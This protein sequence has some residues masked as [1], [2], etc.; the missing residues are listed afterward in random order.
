MKSRRF[1][2]GFLVVSMSLYGLGSSGCENYYNGSCGDDEDLR[3]PHNY[4][5]GAVCVDGRAACP[6]G[7]DFCWS[8]QV[9]AGR[10]NYVKSCDGPCI[11]CPR[12]RGACIIYHKDTDD[13]SVRC[14]ETINDCWSGEGFFVARTFKDQDQCATMGPGCL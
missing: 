13:Y 5:D 9:V 10:S 4:Y 1:I 8:I 7:N 2:G 6:G 3:E 12:G 11:E 14:V